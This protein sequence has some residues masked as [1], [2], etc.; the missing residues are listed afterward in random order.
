[1]DPSAAAPSPAN[2]TDARS[3]ER[4]HDSPDVSDKARALVRGALALLNAAPDEARRLLE[5]ALGELERRPDN[6]IRLVG[7]RPTA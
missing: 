1:M 4:P 2:P 5:Q 7:R 6:V 3:A